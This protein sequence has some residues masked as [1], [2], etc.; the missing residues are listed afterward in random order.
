MNR[1]FFYPYVLSPRRS[2]L[3]K[4]WSGGRGWRCA[5]FEGVFNR[6]KVQKF[7]ELL[8][9]HSITIKGLCHQMFFCLKAYKLKS[10]LSLLVQM[11]F[12]I[13]IAKNSTF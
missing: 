11:V 13:V 10:V 2:V 5:E 3:H 8:I 12:C 1:P 4:C 7:M 6:A 9:E